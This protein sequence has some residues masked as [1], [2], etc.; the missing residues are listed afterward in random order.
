M[1]VLVAKVFRLDIPYALDSKV[2]LSPGLVYVEVTAKA[3]E[4]EHA[5]ACKAIG[6]Q[7][8]PGVT[9]ACDHSICSLFADWSCSLSGL[10]LQ[11]I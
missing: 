5:E 7:I 11:V 10:F 6:T 9:F 1:Q 4:G 2:E 3:G 8:L